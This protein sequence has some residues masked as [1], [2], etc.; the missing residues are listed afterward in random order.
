VVL[1][2]VHARKVL[3]SPAR[4]AT[5]RASWTRGSAMMGASYRRLPDAI[6]CV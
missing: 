4:E 3:A 1:E 6:N 2:L 5:F